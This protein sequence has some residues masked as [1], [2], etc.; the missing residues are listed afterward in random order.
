MAKAGTA[1][2]YRE[3]RA[4]NAEKLRD[5][6]RTYDNARYR[7]NSEQINEKRAEWRNHNR[8][9][10]S[11]HQ[12]VAYALRKGKLVKFPCEVCGEVRV[13]AHHPD[14]SRPLEVMWLCSVH[15]KD[16]H[17]THGTV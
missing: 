8:H 6:K 3:Y 17:Q 15:H 4:K 2:Y 9:K 12:K 13:H 10:Y 5:Y 11:A 14:Y 7:K 16:W 1:E